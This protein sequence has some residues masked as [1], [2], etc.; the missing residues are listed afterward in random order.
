MS[1]DKAAAT[2]DAVRRYWQR[3]RKIGHGPDHAW[4]TYQK[5][6]GTDRET[7]ERQVAILIARVPQMGEKSAVE[8]LAALGELLAL[9]DA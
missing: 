1:D 4:E 2:R 8:Y 9:R 3:T 7:L 5:M 6:T